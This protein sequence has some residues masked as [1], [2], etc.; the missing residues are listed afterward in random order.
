MNVMRDR[1]GRLIEYLRVSVTERCNMRCVYCV[2]P[3]DRGY[4]HGEQTLDF[5]EIAEL[6]RALA[7]RGLRRV[8]VTGGEPLLRPN[9]ADL[10]ALLSRIPG[11]DDLSLSTNGILLPRYA[12]ALKRNGLKRV[13]ISLDTLRPTRFRAVSPAG[14]W[15]QVWE[16]I[17]TALRVGFSPVKVNCVLMKGVNDDEVQDFARLT[18]QYPLHVRFIELMPIGNIEFY[19]EGHVYPIGL[20]QEACAQLGELIPVNNGEAVGGGPADVYQ[21]R[22]AQ[23]TLG[24]IGACTAN[25]CARCNRMRLSANGYLYPCLGHGIRFDVKPALRLPP[26]RREAAIMQLLE[27]ALTAKPE[28]HQFITMR[29]HTVF[30]TMRMIGG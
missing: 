16:G 22:G 25:F 12:D 14:H 28:G 10:I 27:D 17:R 24:F 21:I 29:P 13:N 6:V 20:A 4:E 11:I 2:A 23:G 30:R 8:R 1:F 5:T 18:F 9:V 19:R 3:S 15:E 7:Q 26:N